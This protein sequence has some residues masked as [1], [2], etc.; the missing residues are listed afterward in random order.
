MIDFALLLSLL[1][2]GS[3][4]SIDTQLDATLN[5]FSFVVVVVV[6]FLLVT[7]YGRQG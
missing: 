2:Y 4:V 6:V 3:S 7:E 1:C 5:C